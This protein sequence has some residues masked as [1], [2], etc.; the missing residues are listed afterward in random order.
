MREYWQPAGE[1]DF[2]YLAAQLGAEE[3]LYNRRSDPELLDLAYALSPQE[4]PAGEKSWRA[5]VWSGQMAALLGPEAVRRDTEHPD[6]GEV[7]LERLV[8]RL[9]RALR[10]APL[11]AVE[12]AEAGNA[13]AKL[14]DPRF[15][16][17]A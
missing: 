8:P 9:V 3:L 7:Y 16:P 11:P 17:D 10:K 2:W 1:G 6:G 13:L 4:G 5:T 12:R 14:G 15:R